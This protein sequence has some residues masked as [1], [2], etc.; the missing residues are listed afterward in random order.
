M[1]QGSKVI[2][3]PVMLEP[4]GPAPVWC[5]DSSKSPATASLGSPLEG[6]FCAY[7]PGADL[8]TQPSAC[9]F[10]LNP[11]PKKV[12]VMKLSWRQPRWWD[13]KMTP[14]VNTMAKHKPIRIQS[15]IRGSQGWLQ[16]KV[17]QRGAGEEHGLPLKPHILSV[18][19]LIW[20]W[21]AKLRHII[22]ALRRLLK[23]TLMLQMN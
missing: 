6:A 23:V 21:Q 4:W 8:P 5:L 19:L 18:L 14:H 11:P 7:L 12:Q 15:V 1:V 13:A 9:P 10:L 2:K 16:S 3:Y 22:T 20:G 17:L